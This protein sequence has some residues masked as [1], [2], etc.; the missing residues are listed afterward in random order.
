MKKRMDYAVCK[1]L[2]SLFFFFTFPYQREIQKKV[3]LWFEYSIEIKAVLSSD[4][5]SATDAEALGPQNLSVLVEVL[6]EAIKKKYKDKISE[7]GIAVFSVYPDYSD[8]S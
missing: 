5:S 8:D 2:A 6:G 7:V 3:D 4:F 1:Y